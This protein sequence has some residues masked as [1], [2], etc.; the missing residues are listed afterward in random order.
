MKRMFEFLL[1]FRFAEIFCRETFSTDIPVF[2]LNSAFSL[3]QQWQDDDDT[4][5]EVV[6]MM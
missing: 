3:L 2:I 4:V 1:C 6:D 5:T